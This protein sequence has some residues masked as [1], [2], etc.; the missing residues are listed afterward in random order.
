MDAYPLASPIQ[1]WQK[2]CD[3][4][5]DSWRWPLWKDTKIV[6]FVGGKIHRHQCTYLYMKVEAKCEGIHWDVCECVSLCLSICDVCMHANV[7]MMYELLSDFGTRPTIYL[8]T[9][10]LQVNPQCQDQPLPCW[11]PWSRG[12]S[13][14][15]PDPPKLIKLPVTVTFL[16]WSSEYRRFLMVEDLPILFGIQGSISAWKYALYDRLGSPEKFGARGVW[17]AVDGNGA[18]Q[19]TVSNLNLLRR[20][21][22]KGSPREWHRNLWNFTKRH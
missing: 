18:S 2:T 4:G 21:V 16:W 10:F 5:R 20:A 13:L 9:T 14:Q 3:W 7:G 8:G 22:M 12:R 11:Q 17:I 15:R 6:G 1:K 19:R